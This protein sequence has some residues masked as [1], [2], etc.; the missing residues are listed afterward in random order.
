[1]LVFQFRDDFLEDHAR[2]D[3][4]HGVVRSS[5]ID[6]NVGILGNSQRLVFATTIQLVDIPGGTN[7]GSLGTIRRGQRKEG[8]PS[9]PLVADLD[10]AWNI[11]LVHRRDFG[12][13]QGSL[14]GFRIDIVDAQ[15]SI[16][17]KDPMELASEGNGPSGKQFKVGKYGE[18]AEHPIDDR[19]D[20]ETTL[21]FGAATGVLGSVER[22]VGQ[23]SRWGGMMMGGRIDGATVRIEAILVSMPHVGGYYER[24]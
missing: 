20:A 2:K 5:P 15:N 24:S 12:Y 13:R 10:V 4:H 9:H 18:K 16:G 22:V 8:F 7:A 17:S 14:G 6:T 3:L 11:L 21:A 1:M 19:R 23:C